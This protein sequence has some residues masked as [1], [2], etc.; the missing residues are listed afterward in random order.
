MSELNIYMKSLVNICTKFNIPLPRKLPSGAVVSESY[1][2]SKNL[3]S[4]PIAFL[5]K[6]R[7]T[8]KVPVKNDKGDYKYNKR[9][10]FTAIMPNVVHSLDRS[11][12]AVLYELL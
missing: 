7:Y 12:I 4:T 5:N 6:T 2:E 9:K 11:A 1:I 8:F 3:Q 10:M